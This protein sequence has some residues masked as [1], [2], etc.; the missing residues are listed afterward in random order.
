MDD[1]A[2]GYK[3]ERNGRMRTR[4]EEDWKRSTEKKRLEVK[5]RE[6]IKITTYTRE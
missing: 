4:I 1:L 6:E 3:K 5:E 2:S